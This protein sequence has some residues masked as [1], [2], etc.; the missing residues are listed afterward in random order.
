MTGPPWKYSACI[1]ARALLPRDGNIVTVTDHWLQK[2]GYKREEVVGRPISDFYSEAERQRFSEGRLQ[3]FIN[4]GDFNNEER[5]VVTKTGQVLDLIVSAISDRDAAGDVDRMLVA[6]KDVTERKRAE[7]D[8]RVTLAENAR[9]R[10]E[11]EH[12]RDY[13]REEV[14]VA[15]N[16]GRIVGT[17]PVLAQMLKRVRQV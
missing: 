14:N 13:L 16:F 7:R 5:Q 1:F 3:D 9:L 12:E 17:S 10:E 11:L 6:S 15:M 4:Q 2:L 8:L